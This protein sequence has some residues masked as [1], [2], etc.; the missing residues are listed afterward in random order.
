MDR[1]E[2]LEILGVS[3]LS[4]FDTFKKDISRNWRKL[5]IK[6]QEN[7]KELF[8][9]NGA[10]NLLKKILKEEFDEII[11]N[12]NVEKDN[13]IEDNNEDLF[14]EENN[15][16]KVTYG[17]D[18][19]VDEIRETF[20]R[21]RLERLENSQELNDDINSEDK[22]NLSKSYTFRPGVTFNLLILIFII[23]VIILLI[24][25][26]SISIP[27][28]GVIGYLIDGK[29]EVTITNR[30]VRWGLVFID[31]F[32]P[33]E[34]IKN[35][36]KTNNGVRL[37]L[38]RKYQNSRVHIITCYGDNDELYECLNFFYLNYKDD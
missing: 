32:F 10:Y 29:I 33:Y 25:K 13:F 23:I 31:W 9:V 8:R 7:D 11:D 6:Y 27:L 5:F 38:S 1:E 21:Y 18:T 17:I 3:E 19:D 24:K 35:I 2:A 20:E 4:N 15:S 12:E 36:S 37:L 26:I 28:G 34:L 22:F 16:S 14:S 30:G